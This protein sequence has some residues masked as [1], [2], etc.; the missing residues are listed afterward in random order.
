MKTHHRKQIFGWI[1]GAVVIAALALTNHSLAAEIAGPSSIPGPG[2]MVL[3]GLGLI[4][5]RCL[6]TARVGKN[7]ND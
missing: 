2:T 1:L 4:A 3:L 5:L 7:H 6:F